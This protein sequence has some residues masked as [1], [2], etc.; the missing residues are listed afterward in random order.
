MSRH[1]SILRR[2]RR[3][4]V[5]CALAI[6]LLVSGAH[7]LDV[8]HADS[9]SDAQQ[10]VDSMIADLENLRD[11]MGQIDEDYNAALDRKT[12]L[13]DEI[14]V[15]QVKIDGLA[16]QVGQLDAVLTRIAVDRFTSGDTLQLSPVFSDASTYTA[17]EQRAALGMVAIDTGETDIDSLQQMADALADERD[18]MARKQSEAAELITT[19]STK[20]SQ[21]NELEQVYLTKYAQAKQS[22]GEAKLQAAEEKRAAS[23]A[24]RAAAAASAPRST[25]PRG[26]GSGGSSGGSGAVTYPAPSGRAGIAVSAALS[27]LGVPYRFAASEPGVAFDCSGLTGWAWAQAGVSLPHQSGRQYASTAHVPKDQAR[28]GDLIFYYSPIGHVGIY[29]GNGQMVHAPQPGSFVS[30]TNVHWNKVVGVGRPG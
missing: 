17:A 10:R 2:S 25:T 19:L 27:Q 13:E 11:E 18:Y 16:G 22:L 30:V 26:G 21:Y 4:A 9:V 14:S 6:G 1:P 8:A 12:Q 20:Q 23:A 3:A 29:I 28:P 24:A 15:S 5:C 7:G